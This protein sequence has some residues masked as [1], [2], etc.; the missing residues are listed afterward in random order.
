MA[1]VGRLPAAAPRWAR[2]RCSAW[3]SGRA[4]AEAKE[5]LAAAAKPRTGQGS[6]F[7][8]LVALTLLAE[9]APDQAAEVAAQ[10]AA[11][12][13]LG[14]ELRRDAFQVLLFSLP[15][16]AALKAALDAV[17]GQDPDRRGLA[18]SLLVEGKGGLRTVRGQFYLQSAVA[19][20]VVSAI[21]S[22]E[23]GQALRPPAGLKIEHVRPLLTHTDP[24]VAADA[25]YLAAILGDREGLR[26]LLDYWRQQRTKGRPGNLDRLVYRAIA[27]LDDSSQVAVLRE[28]SL[29]MKNTSD[30]RDLYWTVRGMSGQEMIKFRKEIRD[31]V[32]MDNLR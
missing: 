2:A 20:D 22:S 29:G 32:G 10:M 5:K 21:R 31:K 7:Q 1:G 24:Q 23:S 12:G 17:A 19:D 8:R 18:L 6:D 4:A 28:I 26:P 9:A 11:D 27:A 13:R 30:F 25:G 15:G 14:K 16:D 3:S